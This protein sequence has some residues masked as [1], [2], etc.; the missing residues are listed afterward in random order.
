MEAG[1]I[2]LGGW[3]AGG[4]RQDPGPGMIPGLWFSSPALLV[5]LRGQRKQLGEGAV[6]A[7]G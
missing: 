4:P 7:W 5:R 1:V 3:D 6:E 2:S